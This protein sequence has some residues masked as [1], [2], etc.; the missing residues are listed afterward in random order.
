MPSF[1]YEG[2]RL[3]YSAMREVDYQ[4]QDLEVGIY[5]TSSGF[6]AGTYRMELYL[7][8]IHISEP[9]AD[10]SGAGRHAISAAAR[11]GAAQHDATKATRRDQPNGGGTAHGSG[12]IS[13]PTGGAQRGDNGN[14]ATGRRNGEGKR[15]RHAPRPGG[16]G[17]TRAVQR[18]PRNSGNPTEAPHENDTTDRTVCTVRF[19]CAVLRYGPK[20]SHRACREF[21]RIF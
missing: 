2:E 5:F 16:C 14:N 10:R 21:G 9:T 13:G 6:A 19:F 20:I 8:L 3:T 4:N 1:E 12:V 17:A 15:K 18:G 7:S 11:P